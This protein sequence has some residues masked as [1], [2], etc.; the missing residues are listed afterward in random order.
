[1]ALRKPSGRDAEIPKSFLQLFAICASL[2]AMRILKPLL[3]AFAAIAAIFAGLFAAV[4]VA[5]TAVFF[6]IGRRVFRI[7]RPTASRAHPSAT[8][9]KTS[10]GDAI[11]VVA[12]EIPADRLTR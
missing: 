4:V 12:T 2:G 5:L 3:V 10:G 9:R 6:L 7:N 11:D 1:L 8:T